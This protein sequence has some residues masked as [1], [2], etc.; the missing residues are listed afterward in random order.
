MVRRN[1]G[2]APPR[3]AAAM[4]VLAREIGQIQGFGLSELRTKH[5]GLFGEEPKSKNLPFLRRKIGFRI[6]EDLEGGLSEAARERI[7]ELVPARQG[8]VVT[9]QAQVLPL[10]VANRP[11]R[12]TSRD[13]RLP[14]AGST[15]SR[16]FKGFTHEVQVTEDGFTYRGR[17]YRSLSAIAREITGSSW[18]GFLF[19]GLRGAGDATQD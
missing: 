4:K 12:T 13:P 19:F 15:L 3:E 10:V 7:R 5:L 1:T 16:T 17:W 9:P 18:N 6:Q 8:S 2:E 14:A 11:V